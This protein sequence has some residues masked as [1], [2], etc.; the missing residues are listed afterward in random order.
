[1]AQHPT[2]RTQLT[3]ENL[4]YLLAKAVQEWNKVLHA[5]FCEAGFCEV[6]P[7]FGSVLI[8]LF[9]EDGLRMGELARRSRL[10]RQTMTTLVRSM[11]E[12]AL[13]ERHPD[14]EDGRATRIYLSARSRAFEPV[15]NRVLASI[16][17]RVRQLLS[18]A[19]RDDL[20]RAL[21]RLQTLSDDPAD[22]EG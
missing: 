4:G 17:R 14:P 18:T 22:P 7:S 9:E 10:S 15:A 5:G 20:T 16:D 1:V 13:V 3:Q 12:K 6:K 8:P 11:E 21:N 2:Q 19:E